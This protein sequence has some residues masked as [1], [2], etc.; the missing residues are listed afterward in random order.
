MAETLWLWVVRDP[1]GRVEMM[2]RGLPHRST[3]RAALGA[4][5]ERLADNGWTAGAETWRLVEDERSSKTER[6]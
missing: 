2:T 4:S 6:S 3:V 1:H 5:W